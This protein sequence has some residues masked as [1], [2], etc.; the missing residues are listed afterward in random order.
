MDEGSRTKSDYRKRLNASYVLAT[1]PFLALT[2]GV[3]LANRLEPRICGL[4][5]LLGYLVLWVAIT[6]AFLFVAGLLRKRP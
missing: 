5:F 6:P 2:F 1:L 3:P 4:P